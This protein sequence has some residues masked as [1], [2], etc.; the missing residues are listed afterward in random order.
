MSPVHH[1]IELLCSPSGPAENALLAAEVDTWSRSTGTEV[2]VTRLADHKDGLRA[3]LTGAAAQTTLVQVTPDVVF[4]LARD[5]VL[6][7]PPDEITTPAVRAALGPAFEVDGRQWA[8]PKDYSLISLYQ[9]ADGEAGG[10]IPSTFMNPVYERIAPFL[11]AHG[12]GTVLDGGGGPESRPGNLAGLRR[13]Q[14]LF[15][16]GMLTFPQQC[17]YGN[18]VTAA[19]EGTALRALEG[20]WLPREVP[21]AWTTTS[22]QELTGGDTTLALTGGWAVTSGSDD[23]A[24]DLV[25]FLTAPATLERI[26]RHS[27]PRSVH[28]I[29][30]AD[31]FRLLRPAAG[32]RSAIWSWQALITA[33]PDGRLEPLADALSVADIGEL[34]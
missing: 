2:A 32:S 34:T 24:W 14:E 18:T 12:G 5:K 28:E 4:E 9:R 1:S 3:Y 11:Y 15:R 31:D 30:D 27:G 29:G 20:P 7:T 16:E 22:L 25:R 8:V 6:A 17:G 21:A 10:T 23:I 19:R 13:V 33:I 26:S